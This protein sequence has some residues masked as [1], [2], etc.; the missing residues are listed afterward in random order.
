MKWLKIFI[1]V[2]LYFSI[3]GCRCYEYYSFI[4]NTALIQYDLFDIRCEV[5]PSAYIGDN[6]V[7]LVEMQYKDTANIKVVKK[8]MKIYP[9]IPETNDTLKF[10]EEYASQYS[11]ENLKNMPNKIELAILFDVDSIGKIV[12]KKIFCKNLYRQKKCRYSLA[13]H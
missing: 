8:M 7:L 11:F 3:I 5:K 4:N 13:L 10:I 12:H 1:I 2:L 9:V 6:G